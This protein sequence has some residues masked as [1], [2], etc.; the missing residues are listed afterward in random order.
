MGDSLLGYF[1]GIST[2]RSEVGLLADKYD[3]GIQSN[4]SSIDYDSAQ[5]LA[6]EINRYAESAGSK[7]VGAPP[8]SSLYD[9]LE[10]GMWLQG[11]I[12]VIDAIGDDIADKTSLLLSN[13]LGS[14]H[15]ASSVTRTAGA[16]LATSYANFKDS[17]TKMGYSRPISFC[18]DPPGPMQ[19]ASG[20]SSYMNNYPASTRSLQ[21]VG[22]AQVISG[23]ESGPSYATVIGTGTSFT[24]GI[25]AS[26]V[27]PNAYI[28][29][30]QRIIDNKYAGT[31]AY[32]AINNPSAANAVRFA[33]KNGIVAAYNVDALTS[34]A[35]VDIPITFAGSSASAS[36]DNAWMA[37]IEVWTQHI[38]RNAAYAA[39]NTYSSVVPGSI[40]L[41]RTGKDNSVSNLT[42]YTGTLTWTNDDGL[43]A[44]S[45][46]AYFAGDCKYSRFNVPLPV[47][48]TVAGTVKCVFTP[49][50]ADTNNTFVVIAR[51]IFRPIKHPG[52]SYIPKTWSSFAASNANWNSFINVDSGQYDPQALGNL[53]RD[54]MGA[55]EFWAVRAAAIS[56]ANGPYAAKWQA[57]YSSVFG[58][59]AD[60]LLN[61][62]F[63]PRFFTD[64]KKFE[65]FLIEMTYDLI[66]QSSLGYLGRDER[67]N[68][69]IL[70]QSQS[71]EL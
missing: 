55:E 69:E 17:A 5:A 40:A 46:N 28:D 52:L 13:Y 24:A 32:C 71:I 50:A 54:N 1:Q 67:R 14:T 44:G 58:M 9:A 37:E 29:R 70:N 64:Q 66:A 63:W 36:V 23:E 47:A 38:K 61:P 31:A 57:K 34:S 26:T 51:I 22:P 19:I 45:V 21:P 49:T 30:E 3:A 16:A 33:C 60:A 4:V 53:I 41:T 18:V 12:T 39:T 2:L 42:Q 62:V 15:G 27:A 7:M 25:T 56:I 20:M 35:T 65:Q 8:S 6:I 11:C 48:S 59:P 10:F 68:F 43:A